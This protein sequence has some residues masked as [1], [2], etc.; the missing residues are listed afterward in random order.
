MLGGGGGG[1]G[2]WVGAWWHRSG[3]HVTVYKRE[4]IFLALNS[5]KELKSP[6]HPIP[7]LHHAKDEA[8]THPSEGPKT[9]CPGGEMD[10]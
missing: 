9:E 6:A 2:V 5:L 10:L 1:A 4:N 3:S 8:D 7:I